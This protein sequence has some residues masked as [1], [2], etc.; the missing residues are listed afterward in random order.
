MT[1]SVIIS[2]KYL[3]ENPSRNTN[4]EFCMGDR[5]GLLQF[6]GGIDIVGRQTQAE[7][8]Q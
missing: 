3:R 8:E 4:N 7:Q 1:F 5:Q 6:R 2:I